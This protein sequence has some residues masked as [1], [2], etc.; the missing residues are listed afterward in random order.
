M[1]THWISLSLT[2]DGRPLREAGFFLADP[3]RGYLENTSAIP[4][5]VFEQIED[6]L[7]RGRAEGT[8]ALA[9]NKGLPTLRGPWRAVRLP[10][11]T[12]I[13]LAHARAL[14]AVSDDF[15]DYRGMS[16]V[17]GGIR[18]MFGEDLA[19][20][21]GDCR[22]LLAR[23]VMTGEKPEILPWLVPASSVAA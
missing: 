19:I 10:G 7:R 22:T 13:A 21:A 17:S 1:L 8:V 6:D 4:L 9:G 12:E 2:V 5:A 15:R 23:A 3:R 11:L 18:L 14:E 16:G 20:P